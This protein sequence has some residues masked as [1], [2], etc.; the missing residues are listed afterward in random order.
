[1][2]L[3]TRQL[4]Y[5]RLKRCTL[6]VSQRKIADELG[7]KRA[8]IGHLENRVKS[9]SLPLAYAIAKRYDTLIECLFDADGY[10]LVVPD[11]SHAV[12]AGGTAAAGEGA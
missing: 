11:G 7:V 8:M 4:T 2:R 5:I 10:A 3:S 6:G 9:P 1:M 12:D